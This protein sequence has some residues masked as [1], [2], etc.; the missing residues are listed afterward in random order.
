M[1]ENPQLESAQKILDYIER[2]KPSTFKGR[3]ILRHTNF[4]TVEDIKPGL[5]ILV[6][7]GYL[8]ETCPESSRKG[9]PE[10]ITYQVNP[11]IYEK[12]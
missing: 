2:K 12:H 11:V 1:Q 10:G 4:K 8:K 6:E 7:R 3:D 5:K 9:R